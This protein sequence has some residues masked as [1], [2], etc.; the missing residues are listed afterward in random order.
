[1][2]DPQPNGPVITQ[3]PPTRT[4]VVWRFYVDPQ[5][6]W[7]WQQLASDQNVL[8]DSTGAHATYDD[9]VRDAETHGYRFAPSQK[10]LVLPSR[11]NTHVDRWR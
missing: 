4:N 5:G 2:L 1:M 8:A 3:A 9:C 7:R 11:T 10:K 6:G